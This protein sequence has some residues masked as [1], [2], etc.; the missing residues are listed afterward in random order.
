LIVN[1]RYKFVVFHVPKT[2]GTSVRHFFRDLRGNDRGIMGD[3]HKTARDFVRDHHR[4]PMG[5]YP[6]YAIKRNP[7]DRL[8]SSY[9]HMIQRTQ[10]HN[11]SKPPFDRFVR[12]LK[13]EGTWAHDRLI[14]SSVM[15]P[16][17]YFTQGAEP[18]V[19]L[20]PFE[21]L[22]E[23]VAEIVRRHK[24]SLPHGLELP[25]KNASTPEPIEWSPE[26]RAIV[27]DVYRQDFGYLGY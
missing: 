20:L 18:A 5:S 25:H 17:I 26:L 16:Q 2:G 23:S 4:E 22:A 13:T 21:C 1:H 14:H 7:Y 11:Q 3:A 19:V 15:W 6:M 27:R 9:Q 24:V 8:V 12:D 10:H